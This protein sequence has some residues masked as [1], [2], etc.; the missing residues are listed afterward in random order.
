VRRASFAL[1]L[2]LASVVPLGAQARSGPSVVVACAN[3][4]LPPEILKHAPPRMADPL[5]I[6]EATGAGKP[7]WLAVANDTPTRELGL[8][9]VTGLKP[10]HGMLFVFAQAGA[11]PFWMKNTLI[12]LDMIW[13]D[14]EGTVTSVAADV[15]A[16]T[17]QTPDS[18]VARR[19]GTGRFVVEIAAG[20]AL[21]DG[22]S[23][24]SHFV[25]PTLGA[26]P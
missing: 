25:L 1:L 26:S 9:C 19:T 3:P 10:Q 20:E 15:P 11:Q 6:V 22:I 2:A 23:A 12:P 8:M 7:L 24:G 16:S 13:L 18:A 17:R 4:A 5:A 14:A 21:A